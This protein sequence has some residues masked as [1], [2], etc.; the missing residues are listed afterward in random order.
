VQ[1]WPFVTSGAFAQQTTT[2]PG[3]ATPK[4]G[5]QAHTATVEEKAKHHTD[6]INSIAQLS[7]DQYAKVLAI[8]RYFG[9]R[10]EAL[11]DS[12]VK[13][14]DPQYQVLHDQEQAQLKEVLTPDQFAKVQ[15]V[16]KEHEMHKGQ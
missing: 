6:H 11:I 12:A 13:R 9:A 5:A 15:A 4:G 8:V 1:Q 14:D 3:T 10:K 7:A 16:R 2:T